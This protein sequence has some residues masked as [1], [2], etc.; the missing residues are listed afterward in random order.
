MTRSATARR[1]GCIA[2]TVAAP[3]V[4]RS[5]IA[6]VGRA[7]G[8]RPAG[9]RFAWWPR[10]KLWERFPAGVHAVRAEL[11]LDR[12]QAVVLGGAFAP[13]GRTGLD[14]PRASGDHEVGDERVLGLAGAMADDRG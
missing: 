6:A 7:G 13:R 8:T 9:G 3:S 12:E 1:R 14:L 2:I 11:G 5:G 10:A 4:P